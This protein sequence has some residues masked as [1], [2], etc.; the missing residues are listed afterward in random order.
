M[1]LN[2]LL[3]AMSEGDREHLRDAPLFIISDKI[4]KAIEEATYARVD[5][6]D[7]HQELIHAVR[8]RLPADKI[9]VHKLGHDVLYCCYNLDGQTRIACMFDNG[10][11]DSV[12]WFTPG[13]PGQA[14]DTG[15]TKDFLIEK[16]LTVALLAETISLINTPAYTV[17]RP[18]VRQ[19]KRA[20]ARTFGQTSAERIRVIEWDLTK[21]KLAAG[22]SV[23]S[24]RH[25]PLHYTRGHWR[26]C[27]AHH[28]GATTHDD[29]IV[30]QWIEGFWSG[31]PAYGT[32]KAVY[33][34]TIGAM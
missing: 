32:I 29:G 33:A 5:S 28:N 6:F 15:N 13:G 3:H 23:G 14:Y 34:P 20:H 12:G 25:M 10:D 16:A 2:G 8:A 21:P 11:W 1:D 30:R 4:S 9:L 7:V 22:E 27:E 17:A 18:L 26:K 19:Q 24:G 31:H